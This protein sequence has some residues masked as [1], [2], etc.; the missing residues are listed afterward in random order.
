MNSTFLEDTKDFFI[1][2]F[3]I[4]VGG[5]LIVPIAAFILFTLCCL[6]VAANF[7]SL[8]ILILGNTILK[9]KPIA[10]TRKIEETN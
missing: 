3:V 5:I 9:P 7:I 6:I 2:S 4:G 1:I 8:I 10:V